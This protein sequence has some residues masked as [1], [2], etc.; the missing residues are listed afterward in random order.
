MATVVNSSKTEGPAT[1]MVILGL[2]YCSQTKICNL[3]SAKVVTYLDR[4]RSMLRAGHTTSKDLERLTG[5]LEF[6]AW[7]EPFCLLSASPFIHIPRDHSKP[8]TPP[9]HPPLFYPDAM[10]IWLCLL[11]RNRGLRY[12]YILNALPAE[13]R[14]IFVDAASTGGIGGYAS[15]T[16][17]P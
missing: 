1:T 4:I 17:F 11:Q 14:R 13:R 15:Y 9:Y 16:Y 6:A 7:V 2:H 5:N 10:R 12:A 3:D 8:T